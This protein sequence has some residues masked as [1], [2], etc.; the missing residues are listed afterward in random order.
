[1]VCL[2]LICLSTLLGTPVCCL[3]FLLRA[4]MWDYI[5][6]LYATM[7]KKL[8]PIPSSFSPWWYICLP[9]NWWTSTCEGLELW[10]FTCS[11]S[12]VCNQTVWF[13]HSQ[14]I[15]WSLGWMSPTVPLLPWS[16]FS[17]TCSLCSKLRFRWYCKL[18][19][20]KFVVVM[21]AYD[22]SICLSIEGSPWSVCCILLMSPIKTS[23][24]S[25]P[26]VFY[27]GLVVFDVSMVVIYCM[28]F[29]LVVWS[30]SASCGT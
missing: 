28:H 17:N 4:S 7:M 23:N 10:N 27:P 19:W 22:D 12:H 21:V 5:H 30:R 16:Y 11:F 8:R 13:I 14:T 6:C 20:G 24:S 9:I 3:L 18:I 2:L 29:I 26:N 1:M 15:L 25:M